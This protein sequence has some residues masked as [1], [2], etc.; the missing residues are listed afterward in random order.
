MWMGFFF[1]L[2]LTSQRNFSCHFLVLQRPKFIKR[3]L[4]IRSHRS[5]DWWQRSSPEYPA[6]R[7]ASRRQGKHHQPGLEPHPRA[8]RRK[9]GFV[10]VW[11]AGAEVVGG[12]EATALHQ[13]SNS[14]QHLIR[15]PV[16]LQPSCPPLL[17]SPPPLLPQNLFLEDRVRKKHTNK[18]EGL[19]HMMKKLTKK[20][21]T[22]FIWALLTA[23][24][25]FYTVISPSHVSLWY[26][27]CCCFHWGVN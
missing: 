23:L 3:I 27:L 8:L 24:F 7:G 6:Y 10:D 4:S 13:D 2:W 26:L 1:L 9:W 25:C 14:S 17:L 20:L 12:E 19:P 5:S 16:S 15:P 22:L 21:I 11:P 18:K